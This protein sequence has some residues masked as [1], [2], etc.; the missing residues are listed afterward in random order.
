MTHHCV[1]PF[2]L[3]HVHA[4]GV[5]NISAKAVHWRTA[6]HVLI[7]GVVRAGP[8]DVEDMGCLQNMRTMGGFSEEKH[9]KDDLT[10]SYTHI[11]SYTFTYRRHKFIERDSTYAPRIQ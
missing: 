8:F 11:Y 6:L 9:Q 1:Q 7:G 4:A 5:K 2:I 10:L 3:Q